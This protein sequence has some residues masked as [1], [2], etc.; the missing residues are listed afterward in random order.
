MLIIYIGGEKQPLRV[1]HVIKIRKSTLI[2]S[3]YSVMIAS[4]FGADGGVVV[5]SHCVTHVYLCAKLASQS[6]PDRSVYTQVVCGVCTIAKVYTSD[7][8]KY[9]KA[10]DNQML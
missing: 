5:V 9:L 6:L 7:P 2:S 10:F 8:L 1:P 3:N 4:A